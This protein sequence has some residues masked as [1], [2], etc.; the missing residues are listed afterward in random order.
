MQSDDFLSLLYNSILGCT[1]VPF[2]PSVDKLAFSRMLCLWRSCNQE[3]GPRLAERLAR[4]AKAS[5]G[6]VGF[7]W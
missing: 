3:I 5:V 7:G 4:D 6:D 1:L 2:Q